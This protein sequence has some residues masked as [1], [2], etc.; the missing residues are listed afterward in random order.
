M[1]QEVM[2]QEVQDDAAARNSGDEE[3]AQQ[4]QSPQ[5]PIRPP[6]DAANVVQ[7]DE[8][9]G[10][11]VQLK[12]EEVAQAFPQG[13][14][15]PGGVYALLCTDILRGEG[16]NAG[17]VGVGFRFVKVA[18]APTRSIATPPQGLIIPS[19]R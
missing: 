11:F 17:M 19:G 10:M 15:A 5:P 16:E 6:N 18:M 12:E 2:E 7:P 8:Y 9:P 1:E 14:P 3:L 4:A 13:V